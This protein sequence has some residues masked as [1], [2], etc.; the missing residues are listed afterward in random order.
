M[1]E[2]GEKQGKPGKAFI[3]K[4]QGKNLI[5]R[6]MGPHGRPLGCSGRSLPEVLAVPTN[7]A[8]LGP[9][10]ESK[11]CH[12]TAHTFNRECGYRHTDTVSAQ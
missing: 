8:G 6:S 2:K 12:T 11:T 10:P 9:E 4:N 5:V 3:R 7:D 1:K